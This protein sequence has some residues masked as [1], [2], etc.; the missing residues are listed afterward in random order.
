MSE[1]PPSVSALV[2]HGLLPNSCPVCISVRSV[3][4][5]GV[6]GVQGGEDLVRCPVKAV[7]QEQR[8]REEERQEYPTRPPVQ[9]RPDDFHPSHLAG[10]S[11]F[12]SPSLYPQGVYNHSMTLLPYVVKHLYVASFREGWR[13]Y[14]P[15]CLE[16]VFSET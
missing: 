3:S 10:S 14:S 13:A 9:N 8:T 5:G 1:M 12:T 11:P 7:A 16:E 4:V 6:L 15:D 2:L